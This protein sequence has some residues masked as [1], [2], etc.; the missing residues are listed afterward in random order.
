MANGA[1]DRTAVE[2]VTF[3]LDDGL[4]EMFPV[5]TGESVAWFEN[6]DDATF[7]AIAPIVEAGVGIERSG[8]RADI[9]RLRE[10]SGLVFLDLDDQGD[11]YG[12]GGF[13]EFF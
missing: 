5:G 9:L 7:D 4:D 10:Q 6:G 2:D 1:V 13:E 3:D 8:G 11:V 12:A